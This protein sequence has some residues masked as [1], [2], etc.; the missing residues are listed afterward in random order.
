MI[1]FR[2]VEDPQ[3]TKNQ[4]T[5]LLKFHDLDFFFK[6]MQIEATFLD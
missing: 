3:E 6:N 5:N 4:K 1:V 2:E